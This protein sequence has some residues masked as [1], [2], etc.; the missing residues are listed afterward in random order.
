MGV[1]Y[2]VS[3]FDAPVENGDTFFAMVLNKS[4]SL[5]GCGI[6]KPKF[7]RLVN[8]AWNCYVL[9]CLMLARAP[10]FAVGCSYSHVFLLFVRALCSDLVAWL[11]GLKRSMRW[12]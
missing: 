9:V 4:V 8:R 1:L 6:F 11:W 12:F 5:L 3:C 2:E 10:L 7:V